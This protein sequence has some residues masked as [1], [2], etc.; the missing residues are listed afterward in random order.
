MEPAKQKL[1]NINV[2]LDEVHECNIVLTNVGFVAKKSL[3]DLLV[4]MKVC[5]KTIMEYR[6]ECKSA[7]KTTAETLLKKS[8]LKYSN[9]ISIILA[10]RA[11]SMIK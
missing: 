9:K 1:L 11:K 4:A 5:D 8:P 7:L 2:S 6:L 10:K 3:K